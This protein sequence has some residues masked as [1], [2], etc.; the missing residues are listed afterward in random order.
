MPTLKLRLSG[1]NAEQQADALATFIQARFGIAATVTAEPVADHPGDLKSPADR[2]A[3]AALIIALPGF[4]N[5]SLDLAERIHLKKKLD[6]LIAWVTEHQTGDTTSSYLN[7]RGQP[8]LL[9]NRNVS[10]IIDDIL[11]ANNDD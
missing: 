2:V 11:K 10:A 8:I 5:E 4:A 9:N 7:S 1:A 6:S 3:L